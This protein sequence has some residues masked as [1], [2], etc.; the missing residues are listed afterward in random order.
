MHLCA[1]ALLNKMQENSSVPRFILNDNVILLN[2]IAKVNI[3]SV[4]N[5]VAVTH[6]IFN[7]LIFIIHYNYPLYFFTSFSRMCN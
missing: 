6:L 1:S 7:V 2:Y 3:K 4:P 5:S